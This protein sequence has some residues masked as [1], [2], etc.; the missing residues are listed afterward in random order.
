MDWWNVFQTLQRMVVVV[1]HD[2]NVPMKY[3]IY[4]IE[5]CLHVYNVVPVQGLDWKTR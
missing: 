3:V 2:S 4:V 5:F 1:M